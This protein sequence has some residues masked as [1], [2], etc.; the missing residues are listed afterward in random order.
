MTTSNRGFSLLELLVV[1]AIIGILFAVGLPGLREISA[2]GA[3]REASTSIYAALNRARSE[4]IARNR[5]VRVCSRDLTSATPR[6]ADTLN[7]ANGLLVFAPLQPSGLLPLAE[8]PPISTSLELHT[9][10]TDTLTFN[11]SGRPTQASEFLLCA[12]QRQHNPRARR[13]RVQ[14]SGGV[15]LEEASTCS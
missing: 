6:C 9:A 10:P 4:A 2:A 5:E 14:R 15:S 1:I 7:W 13:I 3:R 8:S 11:A 12:A